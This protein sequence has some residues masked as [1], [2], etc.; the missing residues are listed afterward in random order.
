VTT[1]ITYE[2][3][4]SR[5]AKRVKRVKP[6]RIKARYPKETLFDRICERPMFLVVSFLWLWCYVTIPREAAYFL[7]RQSAAVEYCTDAKI[8]TLVDH[9]DSKSCSIDERLFFQ[10]IAA[11]QVIR[12]EQWGA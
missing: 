10:R 11:E 5:Y 9:C 7:I 6:K 3:P 2:Q 8:Q 1:L 12:C 4:N